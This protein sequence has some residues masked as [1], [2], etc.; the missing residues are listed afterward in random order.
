MLDVLNS[1]YV[2]GRMRAERPAI[3]TPDMIITYGELLAAILSV[4]SRIAT[5]S[6]DPEKPVAVIIA[7]PARHLAV[8]LALSKLGYT[9]MSPPRQLLPKAVELGVGTVIVDEMLATDPAAQVFAR[10]DWFLG[11]PSLCDWRVADVDDDR[12]VRIA[13]TSGSTGEA[14]AVAFTSDGIWARLL[15]MKNRVYL[16]SERVLL[17]FGLVSHVGY[18]AA[19]AVLSQ[20]HTL[21]FARTA[22]EAALLIRASA[23]EAIAASVLQM[24]ALVEAARALFGRYASFESVRSIMTGGSFMS[25]ELFADLRR[26][27]RGEIYQIYASTEAG[28][29]G[30]VTGAMMEAH[31]ASNRFVPLSDIRIAAAPGETSGPVAIRPR[32]LGAPYDGGLRAAQGGDGWF[33]PGDVGHIDS[34]GYLVISGRLDDLVNIGGVKRSVEFF[35]AHFRRAPGVQDCAIARVDTERGPVFVLLV[36]SNREPDRAGLA[37]WGLRDNLAFSFEHVS[38]IPAVPR[39]ASDKVDREGVR[40]MARAIAQPGS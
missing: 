10:D 37:A 8:T 7:D 4:E 30:V 39:N 26:L 25:M 6:L 16:S 14:K 34:D 21:Y 24:K 27:F 29:A 36:V 35:E 40:R 33:S 38:R 31:G 17:Q 11:K 19:L 1:I 2:M 5:L 12:I 28:S 9:T 18:D 13:L 23:I 15:E 3:V 20:G 32:R 22:S